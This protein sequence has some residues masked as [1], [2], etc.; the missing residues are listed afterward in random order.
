[1]CSDAFKKRDDDPG[2]HKLAA[3]DLEGVLVVADWVTKLR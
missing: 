3:L 1:M 2:E